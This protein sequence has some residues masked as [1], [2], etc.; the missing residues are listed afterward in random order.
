MLSVNTLNMF[1]WSGYCDDLVKTT[2]V[3]APVEMTHFMFNGFGAA[4]PAVP[5]RDA[6]AA[7]QALLDQVR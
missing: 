6:H 1:L 4:C 5:H 2:P 7:T 3:P